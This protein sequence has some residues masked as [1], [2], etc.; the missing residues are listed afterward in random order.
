MVSRDYLEKVHAGFRRL[1]EEDT[2]ASSRPRSWTAC[3]CG[4]SSASTCPGRAG[5]RGA[6]PDGVDAAGRPSP[7]TTSSAPPT[8]P[9][10]RSGA[11]WPTSAAGR[12][13]TS[14]PAPAASRSTWPPAGTPWRPS[15][16]TPSSCGPARDRARE[17]ALPVRATV[18]DARSFDLGSRHPL[19]IMPMQVA[20]LLG[21]DARPRRR[22]SRAVA[23]H[24]APG[25]AARDRPCRPLRHRPGRRGAAAAARHAGG[26]R[27]GALRPPR[28]IARDEGDG[29]AID[30]HRQAVSPAGELTEEACDDPPGLGHR[31]RAGGRGRRRASTVWPAPPCPPR[32]TTWAARS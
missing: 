27:L 32:A 21:G 10:C 19:A 29:V 2:S 30:R 5:G 14:A 1:G 6:A 3:R 20:Q 23:Q 4:T 17:R 24:L 9:T 18:A 25:R 12:C 22:C 28:S 16:R 8:R 26:R 15:T 31:R 13:S 7:G 11:S